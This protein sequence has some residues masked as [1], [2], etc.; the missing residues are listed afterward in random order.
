VSVVVICTVS[1]GAGSETA[2]VCPAAS[3]SGSFPDD[4]CDDLGRHPVDHSDDPGLD[5]EVWGLCTPQRRHACDEGLDCV[6]E[7]TS[8]C[9]T[10]CH[11][12]DSVYRPRSSQCRLQWSI[13]ENSNP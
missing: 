11:F 12:V 2:D 13:L 8:D 7:M 4:G 5:A 9:K 6:V 3:A 1:C 10:W